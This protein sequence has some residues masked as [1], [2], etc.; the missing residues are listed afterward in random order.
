MTPVAVIKNSAHFNIGRYG[1][2][3][4]GTPLLKLGWDERDTS[5]VGCGRR[6]NSELYVNGCHGAYNRR[7]IIKN[8]QTTYTRYSIKNSNS[9]FVSGPRNEAPHGRDRPM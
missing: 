5:G 7:V 3:T 1:S 6:D 9:A 4:L 8:P 2:E